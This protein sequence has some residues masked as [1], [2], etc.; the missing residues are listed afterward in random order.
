M[1]RYILILFTVLLGQNIQAQLVSLY[2]HAEK[3]FELQN[4]K[5][6]KSDCKKSR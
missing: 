4:E 3:F 5:I 6:L 2:Y 1:K